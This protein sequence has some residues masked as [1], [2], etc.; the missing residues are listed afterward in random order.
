MERRS[1]LAN[2][3]SATKSASV[4]PPVKGERRDADDADDADP[5][6]YGYRTFP[7]TGRALA[8]FPPFFICDGGGG[9]EPTPQYAQHLEHK[10]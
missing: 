5:G 1:T 7:K 6:V 10:L 4:W 3:A 8:V 9:G 2:V